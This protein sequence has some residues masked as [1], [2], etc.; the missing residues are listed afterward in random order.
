M[1]DK[2]KEDYERRL[3]NILNNLGLSVKK[4]EDEE[5][6]K[7]SVQ[8]HGELVEVQKEAEKKSIE[9]LKPEQDISDDPKLSPVYLS[10]KAYKRMVG[11]ALRY[12][13]KDMEQ[14]EWREVYGVLIGNNE[15]NKRVM[16]KDSIPIMAGSDIGFELE[17]I[18]YVDVSDINTNIFQQSI[19]SNSNDFIVGWWHSHPGFGHFFSE[20]DIMNQ[21]GYQVPNPF[22]VGLVFDHC[23]KNETFLG[24]KAMRLMEP[25]KGMETSYDFVELRYYLEQAKEEIFDKVNKL[26]IKINENM[27]KVLK[28]LEHVEN[29]L[30]QKT[31]P[32]LQ[33]KFSLLLDEDSEEYEDEE[34]Q[35]YIKKSYIWEHDSFK[36]LKGAPKFR[37]RIEAEIKDC[38][39]TLKD[40]LKKGKNDKYKEK[41]ETF[42]KR[43]NTI[44]S[45]PNKMLQQVMDDFGASLDTI[46]PFF[47]FLDSAE[48]KSIE[49]FEEYIQKYF[50]VLDNLKFSIANL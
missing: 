50:R 15:E 21:I 29:V 35:E 2:D 42:Q 26:T 47:D 8:D 7:E 39:A 23:E 12:A 16:I 32:Q 6:T 28:E 38:D 33:K 17:P 27:P 45:K 34:P 14:N 37:S 22:A 44:L 3:K 18:H 5:K 13:N 11:Y 41:K 31:L 30:V 43:I 9:N 4:Y 1:P 40:L 20:I 46:Y 48:R 10:W 25:D 36:N 19:E 49:H 24:V